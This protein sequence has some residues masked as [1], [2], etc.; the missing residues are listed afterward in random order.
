MAAIEELPDS[1]RQ[2]VDEPSQAWL[3]GPS[4]QLT[5]LA[6]FCHLY[7]KAQEVGP[8]ARKYPLYSH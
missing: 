2:T 8:L 4:G 6:Q 3:I 5:G 7:S 1:M